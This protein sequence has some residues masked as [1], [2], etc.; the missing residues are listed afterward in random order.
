M[1]LREIKNMYFPIQRI[2]YLESTG[3]QYIDTGIVPS[4]TFYSASIIVDTQFTDLTQRQLFGSVNA[5][6]FGVN[7]GRWEMHYTKYKNYADT[8]R[9]V[10][11]KEIQKSTLQLIF[12]LDNAYTDSQ[13]YSA[14]VENNLYR[15]TAYLFALNEDNNAICMC[16]CR[17]YG[18]K[19]YIDDVLVRDFTPV[20][21]GNVGYM[22]DKV[23]KQLF[24]NAGTGN[25][26]LG[27]DVDL[28][29]Q[30][31]YQNKLID[32]VD[33]E[34]ADW[35]E[36]DGNAYIKGIK[37]NLWANRVELKVG[38]INVQQNEN[39][40]VLY[41]PES[42]AVW[43]VQQ[44]P[45]LIPQLICI[46]RQ[47]GSGIHVVDVDSMPSQV[48]LSFYQN[49]GYAYCMYNGIEY[50]GK[51]IYQSSWDTDIIPDIYS[52]KMS[53]IREILPD[54]S[55]RSNLVPCKLLRSIP[56]NLDAQC[57]ERVAGECGMIDLISGKFYGNVANSGTFTVENDNNE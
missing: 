11:S 46:F 15:N 49:G 32:G 39:N 30:Q 34:T 53:Y 13:P 26:V 5:F 3:T 24:S 57:K 2:E 48:T 31:I 36:G 28:G 19:I 10:L 6:Y 55:Y 43:A 44:N 12:N 51:K 14:I 37:Y 20:R 45:T 40:D 25:F 38:K 47:S 29:L 18:A 4:E 22:Y 56:R 52:Y 17:L 8:Y 21:V 27:Q 7:N 54:G 23:T 35:L 50:K 16:K 41:F 1:I 9:H 42:G 33:Y